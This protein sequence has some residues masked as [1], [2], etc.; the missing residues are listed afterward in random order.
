MK[1]HFLVLMALMVSVFTF[2]NNNVKHS[3][4]PADAKVVKEIKS[5]YN[6]FRR[7]SLKKSDITLP[8]VVQVAAPSETI[9]GISG[10]VRPNHENWIVSNGNLIITYTKK[11]EIMD[12][13][14]GGTFYIEVPT[15]P[16][17]YYAIELTVE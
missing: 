14:D 12:L 13:Y 8:L 5:S 6:I 2:A 1:K 10:P 9:L 3:E 16:M 11:Y 15:S 7:V 17:R 4:L